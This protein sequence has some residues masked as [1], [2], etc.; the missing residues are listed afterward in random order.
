MVDDVNDSSFFKL[1]EQ[2]LRLKGSERGG[3]SRRIDSSELEED[4][5]DP[6]EGDVEN[7]P[8]TFLGKWGK[9]R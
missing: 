7:R 2:E 1:S 9:R 6:L 5:S 8:D 4:L 3:R